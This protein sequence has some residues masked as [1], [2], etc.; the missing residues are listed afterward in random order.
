MN[1]WL[2]IVPEALAAVAAAGIAALVV[3][4]GLGWKMFDA[5]L[6]DV[7]E[8]TRANGWDSVAAFAPNGT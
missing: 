8:R 2:P 6:R 1:T 7:R 4:G 3:A 5:L